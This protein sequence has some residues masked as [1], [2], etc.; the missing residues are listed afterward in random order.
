MGSF[1]SSLI[2]S[3]CVLFG[4]VL[5]IW[6]G[7]KVQPS[8]FA[9]TPEQGQ[10]LETIPL[11]EGLPTPV[12]RFYKTIYGDE[13]P[14]IKSAVIVG[15]GVL[16]P[17]MNI[18]LPARFVFIH[19]A[20]K[21][22][23]HYFEATLY[24][25]SIMKINE[26]FIDQKSFFESPMAKVYDDSNSNQAANLTLW[27]EAIWFPAIWL[28]DSHVHWEPVDEHSALL[29]VPYGDQEE[30]FLVRFNPDTGLIETMEAMRFR[31]TVDGEPKIL[32]ILQN[33]PDIPLLENGIYSNGS[34]MW[35]DQ[36]SPWAY[37]YVEQIT[38]N[39]DVSDEITQRGYQGN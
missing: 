36:G 4:I 32:W 6:V 29:F 30:N 12:N 19:E 38:L 31:G 11:P 7:L 22:Y 21:D 34:A 24:G 1:R 20:G 9:S 28:T 18:S 23:R 5:L 37:F 39:A 13:I 35:L 2:I 17:F 3:F 10:P 27:A 14:V 26:G 8:S 33:T 25:I 16:K 15:R